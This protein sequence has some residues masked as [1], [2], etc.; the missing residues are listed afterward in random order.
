M[1]RIVYSENAPKPIG[2]YSQAIQVGNMLFVSGQIAIDPKTNQLIEDDIEKQ[3][4]RVL[5]N[6][7][8]I[9]EKAGFSLS[10]VVMSFV[11]LK[12]LN[13]FNSFNKV[14]EKY[15]KENPPA[16]VTVQVSKLPRD[17]RVEIAVIAFK[18]T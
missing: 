18:E 11:Y 1:K 2:P 7:K 10:D 17:A 4:E 9:L 6:I 5:E 8:S 14:Y 3:T 16:R 13:D 15:F 12:D